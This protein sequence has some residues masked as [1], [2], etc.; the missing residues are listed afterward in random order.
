[1][2]SRRAKP[3]SA[4]GSEALRTTRRDSDGR[5][6]A[7]LASGSSADARHTVRTT[8]GVGDPMVPHEPLLVATPHRP[9]RGCGRVNRLPATDRNAS[10]IFIRAWGRIPK[11]L[12]PPRR[13]RLDRRHVRATA[14]ASR[15][16][17]FLPDRALPRRAESSS[18]GLEPP[19]GDHERVQGRGPRAGELEALPG[20]APVVASPDLPVGEPREHRLIGRRERVGHR[21]QWV[22]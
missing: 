9:K 2:G 22:R 1:M 6:A 18:R 5:A 15:S 16:A 17:S 19:V 11:G 7:E 20:V 8:I 3:G 10:V 21:V 14:A 13:R 12:S 4:L